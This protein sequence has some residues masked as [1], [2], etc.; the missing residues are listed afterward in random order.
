MKDFLNPFI[1]RNLTTRLICK[2]CKYIVR[3]LQGKKVNYYCSKKS[4][5]IK[6]NND[7]CIFYK[8]SKPCNHKPMNKILGYVAHSEW[9]KREIKQGHHQKQCPKCGLWLF[10]C[11]W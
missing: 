9:M 7:A 5:P 2:S 11:E 6:S 8:Q 3:T 4:M 1:E 10:K